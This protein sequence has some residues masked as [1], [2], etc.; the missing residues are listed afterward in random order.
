MCAPGAA[1][2]GWERGL[3]HPWVS[4][5]RVEPALPT[6]AFPHRVLRVGLREATDRDSTGDSA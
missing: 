3:G 1:R 4:P 2:V 6:A 5:D